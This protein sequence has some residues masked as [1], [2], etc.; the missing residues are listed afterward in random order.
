MP[1]DHRKVAAVDHPV[2]QL[3]AT[4]WSPYSLDP[5]TV[6]REQLLSC[7]EAARWA[8]SSFN[9]QPWYFLVARRESEQEFDVMLDCLLPANQEWAKDTGVLLLTVVSKTFSR[10][11]KPNRVAEHDLGLAVGNLTLQAT[12]LGL[13]VHQMAG[14]DLEKIRQTYDIPQTH[15]P[16]TAIAL[17]H[18]AVLDRATHEAL[19]ERDQTPRSRKSL[20]EFVF[21][22]KWNQPATI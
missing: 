10:N 19:A 13:S 4:R 14:V 6:E 15:D 11:N 5:R 18:A 12:A 2:H 22:S 8:A 1:T 21:S 17:G 3:I 7:L 20:D 9:E 16:V